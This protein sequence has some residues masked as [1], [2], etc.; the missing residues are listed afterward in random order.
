MDSKHL[1]GVVLSL[2]VI[3]RF[4]AQV[5]SQEVNT[6]LVTSKLAIRKVGKEWLVNYSVW[7]GVFCWC[8]TPY[9]RAV[10]RVFLVAYPACL[11]IP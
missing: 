1:Y 7:R 5:S 8:N 11:S 3:L 9:G 4:Q 6:Q 2:L 10:L